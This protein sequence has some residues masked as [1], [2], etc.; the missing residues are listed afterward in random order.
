M[1]SILYLITKDMDLTNKGLDLTTKDTDLRLF[2]VIVYYV[3]RTNAF[4]FI[5]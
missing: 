4:L 5:Y 3:K 2:Y 1:E